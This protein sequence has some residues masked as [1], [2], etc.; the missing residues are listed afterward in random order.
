[1]KR[2][3]FVILVTM[4]AAALAVAPVL[5]ADYQSGDKVTTTGE[6]TLAWTGGGANNGNGTLDDV[7]CDESNT[8]YLLWIFSYDGGDQAYN[9]TTPY[10]VLGGTGGG[11][12]YYPTKASGNEFHFVTPYYAPDT[13]TLTAVVHFYTLSTGK[14]AYNLVISHGCPGGVQP[15]AQAELSV[16]KFFDANANGQW[17]LGE[18]LL[19][20]WYFTIE[21]A[22]YSTPFDEIVDPGTYLLD[23]LMPDQPNWVASGITVVGT[24]DYTINSNTEVEVTLQDGDEVTIYFGNYCLKPSGG[25]T[26]GFWSNKNGQRLIGSDDLALLCALNLVNGGPFTPISAA[27]VRTW[28]LAATATNMAYMLSAQLA[29]MELNVW[30]GV[31]DGNAFYIPYG[32][33]INTLMAAA[34]AALAADGYTPAGDPNRAYQETLKNYL[35]ALN[36]GALVIPSQPCPYT[37]TLP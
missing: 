22:L 5:G 14:G 11:V 6:N 31:V 16:V 29:A 9:G 15:T 32:G 33:T 3:A 34:D 35:D 17:D 19:D 18:L 25:L 7:E 1:M 20:D 21:G 13:S 23:E 27:Q 28:L 2:I 37:F 36:N 12:T 26:L 4:L 10:L 8:G 24:T 30:N